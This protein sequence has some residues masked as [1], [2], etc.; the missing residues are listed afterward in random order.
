MQL[1]LVHLVILGSAI[2]E[3]LAKYGANVM[4]VSRSKKNV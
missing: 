4:I 2:S 3:G 1:L